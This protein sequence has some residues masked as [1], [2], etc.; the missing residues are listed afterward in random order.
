MK[1]TIDLKELL[2]GKMEEIRPIEGTK[3]AIETVERSVPKNLLFD[4]EATA[5]C[6][7]TK[8]MGVQMA[9]GL[10]VE[11]AQ[12]FEDDMNRFVDTVLVPGTDYG[13]IPHCN[14]PSLLK[15]GAEKIMNFLGLIARTEIVNRMEN[16]EKGFFSY[17]A[18]VFLI[19]YNGVVRGEGIGACN[20]Q[21]SKYQKQSGFSLQ[22][23]ILKMTKK[24]ALVDA[25]LN[26]GNLSARF[27]QD[28]EDMN[29]SEG[30]SEQQQSTSSRSY[31]TEKPASQ[32]QIN[33]LKTLMDNN[34][35]SVDVM[36]R[37]VKETYDISD[38]HQVSSRI[39]S[40]LIEHLKAVK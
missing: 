26:V 32:K 11:E 40:E 27:T 7:E 21:E 3:V 12:L 29:L 38:Y 9:K 36:N 10:T 14:K 18:K 4:A 30:G 6:P 17:E 24:R 39:A 23:V 5:F 15:P 34:G 31:S 25:V 35:I 2:A 22:N 1:K 20:S 16:Y 8:P 28:V 13:I 33:Y 37:Y 19:D